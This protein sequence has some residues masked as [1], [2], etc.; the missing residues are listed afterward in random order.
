M[1]LHVVKKC[2]Y[3]PQPRDRILPGRTERR[4]A[5]MMQFILRRFCFFSA[6]RVSSD[7][8]CPHAKRENTLELS[9][10]CGLTCS[11]C[12]AFAFAIWRM[13]E[14]DVTVREQNFHSQVREYIVSKRTE[15]LK[16]SWLTTPSNG[17]VSI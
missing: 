11:E 13:E 15:Q 1:Y 8:N 2:C 9:L 17:N 12:A 5:V 10:L 4:R 14:D 7:V 6:E 16:A 3:D